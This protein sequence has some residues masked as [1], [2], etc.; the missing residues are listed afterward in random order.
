MKVKKDA[1]RLLNGECVV[2]NYVKTDKQIESTYSYIRELPRNMTAKEWMKIQE[3]S[4]GLTY[5]EQ[6]EVGDNNG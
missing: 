3:V 5:G 6:E 2:S 4:N 1:I